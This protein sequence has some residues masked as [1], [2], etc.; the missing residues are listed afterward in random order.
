MA[1]NG[2]RC[3]L[4]MGGTR[5][6]LANLILQGSA[7]SR[8]RARVA[9]RHRG[10]GTQET[11]RGGVST[12]A[13]LWQEKSGPTEAGGQAAEPQLCIRPSVSSQAG[14]PTLSLSLSS[15]SCHPPG[16]EKST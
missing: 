8:G 1:D 11:L 2:L 13:E 15:F 10:V 14:Q 7:E 16:R 12:Q 5:S 3:E 9:S 6:S 4:L